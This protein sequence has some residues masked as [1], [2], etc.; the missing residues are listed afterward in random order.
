MNVV[1]SDFRKQLKW[2]SLMSPMT[3][4]RIR[5]LKSVEYKNIKL[6]YVGHIE[7]KMISH[8]EFFITH[9]ADILIAPC[10]PQIAHVPSFKY[11]ETIGGKI[12]GAT[13]NNWRELENAWEEMLSYSPNY[14][15]DIGGGFINKAVKSKINIIAGCEATSTGINILN[16]LELDFPVFDWNNIPIKAYMHNRYEVGSG[17]WFA[18]RKL[19]NL[20]IC[21]L[22]VLVIGY[23]LVGQSVA[24]TARGLGARVW[25]YD[26][27]PLKMM[28]AASDGFNTSKLDK[29]IAEVDVVITATGKRNALNETILAN[30]KD[31]IIIGNAA[32]DPREICMDNLIFKESILPD[33]DL[34]CHNL[35]NIYLLCQ[36]RL[37]NLSAGKGSAINSFDLMTVLILDTLNFL[38]TNGR[39]YQR[40]LNKLPEAISS[41][42]L[43]EYLKCILQK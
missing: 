15:F 30:A 23:G 39:N 28:C 29:L 40:G 18:F 41:K 1:E 25:I 26:V 7:P 35:K 5:E 43:S 14:I 31:G 36:G 10:V 32:H 20:D 8:L 11:L 38:F 13:S 6:A 34:Y 4:Q 9:G 37:L 2:I 16:D 17:I 24:S 27:D 21:R 12:F 19:T 3:N 42:L 22:N 33:I